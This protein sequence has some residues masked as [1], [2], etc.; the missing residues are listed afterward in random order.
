[1]ARSYGAV[2]PRRS[3][4][5][6]G[7]RG[8]LGSLIG[9]VEFRLLGPLGR[10]PRRVRDCRRASVRHLDGARPGCG[11]RA[12]L[13]ERRSRVRSRSRLVLHS[14]PAQAYGCHLPCPGVPRPAFVGAC[15]RGGA[16]C[17]ARCLGPALGFGVAGWC[18]GR[19]GRRGRSPCLLGA[20]VGLAGGRTLGRRGLFCRPARLVGFAC[21]FA[22]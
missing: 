19:V 1:V 2:L 3:P 4:A 15:V 11:G 22:R 17:L 16:G 6:R 21:R 20:P 10:T 13:A 12:R 7:R 14:H 9:V 5:H 18:W 8:A